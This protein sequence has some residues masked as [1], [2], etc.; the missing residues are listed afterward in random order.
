MKPTEKMT[1]LVLL[2][3][4]AGKIHPVAWQSVFSYTTDMLAAS[5]AYYRYKPA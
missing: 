5:V 3:E 1:R 4:L 2:R